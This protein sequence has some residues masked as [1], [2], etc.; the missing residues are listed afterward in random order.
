MPVG[1]M[2]ASPWTGATPPN[3]LSGSLQRSLEIAPPLQVRGA[4]KAVIA[5]AINEYRV[6]QS[7]RVNWE[8]F[9]VRGEVWRGIKTITCG[10]AESGAAKARAARTRASPRRPARVQVARPRSSRVRWLRR[11]VRSA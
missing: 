5:R 11:G 4:A 6:L 7:V 8:V 3:Q 1:K 2:S 10:D 9:M